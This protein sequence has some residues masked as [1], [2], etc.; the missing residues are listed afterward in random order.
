[1]TGKRDRGGS[2]PGSGR[3]SD[4]EDKPNM[5]GCNLGLIRLQ[6]ER[7]CRTW[8]CCRFMKHMMS[9]VLIDYL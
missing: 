5:G 3:T 2:G 4:T 7:P 1:M 6:A 8:P 9:S